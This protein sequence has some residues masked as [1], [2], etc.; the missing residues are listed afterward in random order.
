[1]GFA[2]STREPAAEYPTAVLLVT[3]P[4]V[5]RM[6]NAASHRYPLD[7]ARDGLGITITTA[8]KCL[9]HLSSHL[10]EGFFSK[11]ARCRLPHRLDA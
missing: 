5:T 3:T 8:V 4:R 1:M 2:M 10:I 11:F 9:R 6:V 7:H